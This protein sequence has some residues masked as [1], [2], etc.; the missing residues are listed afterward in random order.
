MGSYDKSNA[1]VQ[2]N[3][4]AC[5]ANAK[6][7]IDKQSFLELITQAIKAGVGDSGASVKVEINIEAVHDYSSVN[8][9]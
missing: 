2:V 9:F 7:D 6:I 5:H 4:K 1:D 3:I 8:I